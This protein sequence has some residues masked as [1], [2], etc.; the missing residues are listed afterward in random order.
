M[1]RRGECGIEGGEQWIELLGEEM[2]VGLNEKIIA[3][4]GK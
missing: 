2:G 1:S 4:Q 3:L